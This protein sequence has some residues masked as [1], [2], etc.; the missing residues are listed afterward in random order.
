MTASTVLLDKRQGWM[1]GTGAMQRD[2]EGMGR[3]VDMEQ[4]LK[5]HHMNIGCG[6]RSTVFGSAKLLG[7]G[8]ARTGVPFSGRCTN[9][10]KPFGP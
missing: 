7:F 9:D 2:V 10:P 5:N 3:G 1:V 4:V 6:S 8:P